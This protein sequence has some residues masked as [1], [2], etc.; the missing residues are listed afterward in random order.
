MWLNERSVEGF[1]NV[2]AHFRGDWTFVGLV[3]DR[4]AAVKNKAGDATGRRL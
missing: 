3:R 1:N 2:P 4:F